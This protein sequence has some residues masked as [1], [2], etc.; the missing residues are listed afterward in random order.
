MGLAG[1]AASAPAAGYL[2]L[3]FVVPLVYLGG[4]TTVAGVSARDEP[5]GVRA[6]I[7][8]VLAT[9]HMCWGA[10]YL[11]SPRRFARPKG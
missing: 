6:Q 1:I 5:L 4:I 11:T 3:G 10:G 9:M 7:P 8:L 2:T